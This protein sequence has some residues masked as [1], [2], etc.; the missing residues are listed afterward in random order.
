M[1]KRRI[2]NSNLNNLIYLFIF[3]N[4]FL[5]INKHKKMSI[6]SLFDDTQTLI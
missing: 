1:F 2:N 5:N 6:N 3:V 4:V